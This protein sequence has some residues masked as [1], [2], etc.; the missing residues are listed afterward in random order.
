MPASLLFA[1]ICSYIAVF[2]MGMF[3]ALVSRQP[4]KNI[5][6]YKK[7]H[8]QE[9]QDNNSSWDH[10]VFWGKQMY[11]I[12]NNFDRSDILFFKILISI[13]TTTFA[14]ITLAKLL[15]WEIHATRKR[16]K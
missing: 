9:L 2:L 10:P 5:K 3:V 4:N 6:Q 14:L 16:I 13:T 15:T 8:N 7:Y 12:R 11:F 1:L